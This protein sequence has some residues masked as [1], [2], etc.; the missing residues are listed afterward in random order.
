M[1]LKNH[2]Y[3]L[4]NYINLDTLLTKF[5]RRAIK[6]IEDMD[7]F[8]FLTV[9]VKNFYIFRAYWK[10]LRIHHVM[11][12]LQEMLVF[13]FFIEIFMIFICFISLLI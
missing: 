1:I 11:I 7:P 8:S 5:Q 2:Y 4:D 13:C 9:T 6:E 10:N 12:N 3:L